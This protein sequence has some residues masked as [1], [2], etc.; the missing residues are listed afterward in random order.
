MVNN[1]HPTS[2]Q[3]SG[4]QISRKTYERNEKKYQEG[5]KAGTIK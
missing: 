5:I 1:K 4:G 2:N 3:F